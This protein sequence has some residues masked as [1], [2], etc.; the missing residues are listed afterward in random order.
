MENEIEFNKRVDDRIRK[1]VPEILRGSAFTDRKLTDTPT[2]N[3][4]VVNRQYVNLSGTLASRPTSSVATM[5]QK[6]FSTDTNTLITYNR[7]T[8]VWSNGVG[9]VVAQG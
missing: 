8:S 9:S 6:Y 4:S 2:D 7:N 5:A 3:L 1:I